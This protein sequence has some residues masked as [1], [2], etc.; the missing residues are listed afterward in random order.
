M[1]FKARELSSSTHTCM[2]MCEHECVV[3]G[4]LVS[5]NTY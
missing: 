1:L 5:I 2:L 3:A 4:L